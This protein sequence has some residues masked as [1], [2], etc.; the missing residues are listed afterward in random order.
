VSAEVNGRFSVERPRP[1]GNRLRIGIEVGATVIEVKKD[2]RS[3]SYSLLS[4]K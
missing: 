3:S 4:A 1:A 2:A